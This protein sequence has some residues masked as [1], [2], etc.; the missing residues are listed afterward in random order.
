MGMDM[1]KKEQGFTYC[2]EIKSSG[3]RG[4]VPAVV[5]DGNKESQDILHPYEVSCKT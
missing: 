4:D 2:K 3:Q 1:T 5:D